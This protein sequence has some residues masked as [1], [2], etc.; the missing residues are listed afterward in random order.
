[1]VWRGMQ[2]KGDRLSAIAHGICAS[3]SAFFFPKKP[4]TH[5][6]SGETALRGEPLG[7]YTMNPILDG[8]SF[9]SSS[10]NMLAAGD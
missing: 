10:R 5:S 6:E 1:M 3:S 7:S 9:S 4:K 8:K 2:G